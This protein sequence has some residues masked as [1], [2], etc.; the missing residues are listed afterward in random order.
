MKLKKK[1]Q[2]G[3]KLQHF[4]DLL[5]SLRKT[6]PRA[7]GIEQDFFFS[8][9]STCPSVPSMCAWNMRSGPTDVVLHLLGDGMDGASRAT[10]EGAR[11][12]NAEQG[13]GSA[14]NRGAADGMKRKNKA[15]R[16]RRLREK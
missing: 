7:L 2:F 14:Q 8:S 6:P 3:K 1:L 4:R 10:T 13:G 11:N 15:E 12:E 5:S 9:S 16:K